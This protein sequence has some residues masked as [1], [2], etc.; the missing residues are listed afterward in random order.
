MESMP[1]SGSYGPRS[2]KTLE[3]A[4]ITIA[5]GACSV[6]GIY[7]IGP[8]IVKIAD[9]AGG[10]PCASRLGNCSNLTALHRYR[11]A[12]CASG[13]RDLGEVPRRV[14]VEGPDP[15]RGVVFDHLAKPF[16]IAC[17]TAATGQD[18]DAEENFCHGDL[19]YEESGRA[20]SIEPRQTDF[21][22]RTGSEMTLVSSISIRS[23][24]KSG[25]ERIEIR[26]AS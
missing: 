4:F 26:Y 19:R 9:V 18:C 14:Y 23:Y 11:R 7:D 1:C 22:L 20:L 10:R 15:P 17:P 6:T 12:G 16:L 2:A 24:L 8:E 21:T 25:G 5:V 3:D 13:A